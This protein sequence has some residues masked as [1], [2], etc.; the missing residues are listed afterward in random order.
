MAIEHLSDLVLMDIQ[1]PNID[2]TTALTEIRAHPLARK[3][4]VFAITAT[5]MPHAKKSIEASGFDAFISKPLNE[6]SFV[7]T[8]ARFAPMRKQLRE[9]RE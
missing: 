2:G 9:F 6:K 4:P 8:L 3:I 5:V 1:L 7:E